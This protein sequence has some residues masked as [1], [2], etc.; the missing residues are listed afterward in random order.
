M[1]R[2]P[3]GPGCHN[4]H[5]LPGGHQASPEAAPPW[6][7]L[8]QRGR[9]RV[10]HRRG[11]GRRI[12]DAGLRREQGEGHDGAARR[13][14]TEVGCG[15]LRDGGGEGRAAGGQGKPAGDGAADEQLVPSAHI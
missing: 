3:A 4:A 6:S 10:R 5:E 12:G 13:R 15:L 7:L 14:A 11:E 8:R 2:P 9:E 1:H